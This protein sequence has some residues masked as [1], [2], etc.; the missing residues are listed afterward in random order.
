[1]KTKILFFLIT[2]SAVIGLAFLGYLKA[3]PGAGNQSNLPKIEITPSSYDFG[4]IQYKDIVNYNFKIRNNGNV[5]LSINRVA[6]SCG[7]TTAK[8]AKTTL[9]PNEEAELQ[10][11]YN[12]GLMTGSH[13]KGRQERIIYIKS[14]DPVNPQV[15]ASIYGTVR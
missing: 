7:C 12:S 14:N 10:V 2:V 11:T 3:V 9:A 6:T 5:D 13:G 1:M 4:E 8:I 15:E